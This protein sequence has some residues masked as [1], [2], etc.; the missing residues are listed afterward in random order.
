MNTPA[1]APRL[2]IR[3][4]AQQKEKIRLAASLRQLTVS[5]YIRLA[6]AEQVASDLTPLRQTIVPSA[7]FD[8][9]LAALDE[10]T[11]I[12]P[13]LAHAVAQAHAH[14]VRR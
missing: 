2:E 14:I 11:V 3:L 9:L 12:D 6:L 7:F 5:D 4:P 1:Q 8:K 13:T 10:P